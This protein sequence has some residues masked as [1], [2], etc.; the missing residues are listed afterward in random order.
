MNAAIMLVAV[1]FR[2]GIG[3]HPVFAVGI[4]IYILYSA[5]QMAMEAVQSPLRS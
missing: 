5:Y 2:F 1:E 4:G 3:Q